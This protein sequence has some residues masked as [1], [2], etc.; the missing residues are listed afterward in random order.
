[1]KTILA[2]LILDE[3]FTVSTANWAIAQRGEPQPK[4]MN[5]GFQDG[6]DKRPFNAKSQSRKDTKTEETLCGFAPLRLCVKVPL[7]S[8]R[9]KSSRE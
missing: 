1:M 2:A 5:H 8:V 3:P 7:S 4:A 6:T 9:T